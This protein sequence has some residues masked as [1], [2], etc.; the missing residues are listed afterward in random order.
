MNSND[1][2]SSDES[3]KPGRDVRLLKIAS[4][5]MII[6]SVC[7]F[8]ILTYDFIHGRKVAQLLPGGIFT[9]MAGLVFAWVANK[10]A[11]GK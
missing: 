6:L 2:L 3:K 9:L 4:I 8:S 11:K 7:G 1:H 10:K 5:T